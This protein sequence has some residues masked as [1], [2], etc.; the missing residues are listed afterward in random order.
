[1]GSQVRQRSAFNERLGAAARRTAENDSQVQG[2]PSEKCSK[3]NFYPM[4]SSCTKIDKECDRVRVIK[5][6]LA[7]L[8]FRWKKQ[9][10]ECGEVL[11]HLNTSPCPAC[12]D[13]VI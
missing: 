13:K 7:Y 3:N 9:E 6:G 11:I 1:M 12:P 10:I 5:K 8:F 2:T 4:S